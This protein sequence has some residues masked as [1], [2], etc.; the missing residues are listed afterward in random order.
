MLN[1]TRLSKLIIPPIYADNSTQQ[2]GI[3][4][5]TRVPC[6]GIKWYNDVSKVSI[7]RY[8]KTEWEQKCMY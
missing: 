5:I 3:A 1:I 4:V 7:E 6:I 8:L 2:S